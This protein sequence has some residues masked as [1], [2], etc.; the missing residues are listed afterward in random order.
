MKVLIL[1][2]DDFSIGTAG[3]LKIQEAV[4]RVSIYYISRDT[5]DLER[6]K[7]A[8]AI[9]G[10]PDPGLLRHAAALKWLH[11]P[12]TDVE[13]YTNLG[14][15]ANRRVVVTKAKGVFGI[16]ASEHAIALLLSLAR[17][18][19]AY[20]NAGPDPAP[21]QEHFEL[22]RSTACVFGL[23]STGTEAAKRLKA[24]DCRVLAVRRN[25]FEKPDCVDELCLI[26]DLRYVLTQSNII[27]SCL[28]STVE[29]RGLFGAH[30]FSLM[31]HNSVFISV[32]S[33]KVVDPPALIDALRSGAIAG[34]ALDLPHS[35]VEQYAGVPNLLLTPGVAKYSQLL[36]ERQLKVYIETCSRVMQSRPISCTVD[37]FSGY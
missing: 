9:F 17:S 2:D 20:F 26:R 31:G 32:G 24:L 6:F 11:L 30:E 16:P 15:Y 21:P 34:A 23:G 22:A 12:T 35:E 13:G 27:V 28:P 37:F 4:P 7:K 14:L 36:E 10:M 3:L 33:H 19:K 8:E 5:V 18:L 25:I 29:T 1:H